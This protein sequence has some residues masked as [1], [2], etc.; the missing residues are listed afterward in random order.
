MSH[1]LVAGQVACNPFGIIEFREQS[2]FPALGHGV[3][4][5]N[6]LP[7]H[8]RSRALPASQ[9]SALIIRFVGAI[10][11]PCRCRIGSSVNGNPLPRT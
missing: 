4:I 1:E 11:M 8:S 3:G 9:F 2:Q 6:S 7:S 10:P 5:M